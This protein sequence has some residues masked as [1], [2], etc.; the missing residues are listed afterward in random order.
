MHISFPSGLATANQWR[1]VSIF[2]YKYVQRVI[3]ETKGPAITLIMRSGPAG[4]RQAATCDLKKCKPDHEAE[5]T[6]VDGEDNVDEEWAELVHSMSLTQEFAMES[7]SS[8]F[9]I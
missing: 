4:L 5:D 2:S 6:K 3:H 8:L 7:S 1:R 9:F